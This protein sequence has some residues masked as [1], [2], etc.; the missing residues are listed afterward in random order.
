MR[1]LRWLL[2]RRSLL[3]RALAKMK[4]REAAE[5]EE[6]NEAEFCRSCKGCGGVDE[7]MRCSR[8]LQAGVVGV[9]EIKEAATAEKLAVLQEYDNAAEEKKKAE[10]LKKN[11]L[12]VFK[13][14]VDV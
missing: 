8:Y 11:L 3:R 9:L 10:K 5:V 2:Q 12:K 13:E 1:V 7:K 6:L 4:Y 14:N